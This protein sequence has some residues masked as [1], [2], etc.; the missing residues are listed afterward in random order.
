[1]TG[2]SAKP[3]K[4]VQYIKAKIDTIQALSNYIED[5]EIKEIIQ[6][7]I[8]NIKLAMASKQTPP[9]GEIQED[10]R[11]IELYETEGGY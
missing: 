4:R 3:S 6:I 5:E 7:N 10:T 11:T 9:E 1:M 2:V 8:E